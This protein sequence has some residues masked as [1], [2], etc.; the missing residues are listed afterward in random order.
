M[1]DFNHDGKRDLVVAGINSVR[2]FPGDSRG[3]FPLQ[4]KPGGSPPVI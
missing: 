1:A 4:R 2:V 3:S